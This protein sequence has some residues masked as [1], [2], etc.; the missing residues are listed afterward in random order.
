M[1]KKICRKTLWTK[2]K[3]KEKKQIKQTPQKMKYD[4]FRKHFFSW[5]CK[6]HLIE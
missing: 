5:Q 2:K 6:E 4:C 1:K 3:K